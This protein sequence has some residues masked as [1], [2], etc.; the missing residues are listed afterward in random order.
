MHEHAI[1]VCSGD[2]AFDATWLSVA[3]NPWERQG[4]RWGVA[5]DTLP[6][7]HDVVHKPVCSAC[8]AFNCFPPLL[9]LLR[10]ALFPGECA[11]CTVVERHVCMEGHLGD[12]AEPWGRHDMVAQDEKATPMV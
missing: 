9:R 10:F 3:F 6:R 11:K 2:G 1:V 5:D 12:P 7:L 8:R 4:D